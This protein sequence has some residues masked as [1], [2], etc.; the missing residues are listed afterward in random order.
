MVDGKSH[1]ILIGS[2]FIILSLI[3]LLPNLFNG[4][5][6]KKI[7]NQYIAKYFEEE[8]KINSD[9]LNNTLS[10]EKD[11]YIAVLEIPKISLKQ[12]LVHPNSKNNNVN[13]NIEIIKP[14]DLPN[15]KNGNFI[16][17]GHSGGG[18]NAFFTNLNKLKKEDLINIYFENNKYIYK[19][20][21]IYTE[22]KDG[23]I[24]VHRDNSKTVLTL[25]TCD[26]KNK[27][28]QLIIVAELI[29]IS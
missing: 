6:H 10:K 23:D 4:Y 14:S 17:A 13:K 11:N 19:V 1:S 29:K 20:N 8:I 27:D 28:L 16:L 5:N 15:K 12:G 2:F 24:I 18:W 25:T 26:E 7:N 9:E 22:K 3:L 21:N